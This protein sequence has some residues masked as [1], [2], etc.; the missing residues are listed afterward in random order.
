MGL[1]VVPG[2]PG[3]A[4]PDKPFATQGYQG[5]VGTGDENAIVLTEDIPAATKDQVVMLV[6]LATVIADTADNTVSLVDTIN[7]SFYTDY[8]PDRA[9]SCYDAPFAGTTYPAI[10][11]DVQTFPTWDIWSSGIFFAG[12]GTTEVIP[13]LGGAFVLSDIPSGS[14]IPLVFSGSVISAE[15]IAVVVSDFY[16][17]H[18]NGLVSNDTGGSTACD[19]GR[20][21][22]N[23]IALDSQ[24]HFAAARC[25]GM[26]LGGD[27]I[28][29]GPVDWNA[30]TIQEYS[31]A[32]VSRADWSPAPN[33]AF[34]YGVAWGYRDISQAERDANSQNP[35]SQ[36]ACPGVFNPFAQHDE[37]LWSLSDVGGLPHCFSPNLWV[38][39]VFG[40]NR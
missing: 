15:T 1:I 37:H 21:D 18:P 40:V 8:P 4:V 2:Q 22:E 27:V 34:D 14:S 23:I 6:V 13:S 10:S 7:N 33:T 26:T 25:C 17:G 9:Y 5:I 29:P 16:F 38:A 12:P 32:M 35:V 30:T 20:S 36:W 39:G 3:S 24:L 28:D 11:P 31:G 19:G